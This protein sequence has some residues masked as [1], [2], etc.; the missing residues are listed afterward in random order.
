MKGSFEEFLS[1][2]VA[3]ESGWDRERYNAG[4]IIDSQLD[5]WA[6]GTTDLSIV[7]GFVTD[8]SLI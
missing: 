8:C 7:R 5:Q 1:A 3:F 4:T 6:G 2:L